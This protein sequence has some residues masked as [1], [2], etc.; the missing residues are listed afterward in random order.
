ML[1]MSNAAVFGLSL[2]AVTATVVTVAGINGAFDRWIEPSRVVSEKQAPVVQ[3]KEPAAKSTPAE[4]PAATDEASSVSSDDKVEEAEAIMPTKQPTV[5]IVRVEPSG[6]AV[7]AGQSDAGALVAVLSNGAM[8]GKGVAN[9]AGDWAIV[10]DNPL[11]PGPHDIVVEARRNESTEAVQAEIMISVN[12]PE[13][14]SQGVLV[15]TNQPGAPTEVLQVPNGPNTIVADLVENDADVP[16]TT[17]NVSSTDTD[18][19]APATPAPGVAEEKTEE[20]AA[21]V[22]ADAGT[23]TK[24]GA[25]AQQA[26]EAESESIVVAK[27]EP[28]QPADVG[29]SAEKTAVPAVEPQSETDKTVVTEPASVAA[30]EPEPQAAPSEQAEP[31][32]VAASEPEPQAAPSEQAEPASV[33]ASEPEPQAAP[34]E[35]VETVEAAKP[36]SEAPAPETEAQADQVANLETKPETVSP[37]PEAVKAEPEPEPEKEVEPSV[38][39]KAVEAD[40]GQVYIAGESSGKGPIRVYI[41][42]KLLGQTEPSAEGQWVIKAPK[43]MAPGQHNVRADKVK[44]EKGAVLARAEVVFEREADEVALTAIVAVGSGAS[45]VTAGAD[46]DAGRRQIPAMI[47]RKGDSLWRISRRHYGHGIRYTTIYEANQG[48]I[49]NPD[50]IFPGQVFLLPQ[51]DLNWAGN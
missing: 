13:D 41:G 9:D 39:V 23:E 31:A 6:D 26:A 45:G 22:V 44:D 4:S 34:V 29:Q 30:S 33:A 42:E 24:T 49:Q 50:L 18:S 51:R 15:A 5:D 46:V 47:I 8:V 37:K 3:S 40:D 11:A 21:M 48:Q 1:G 27:A 12:V 17:E 14:E 16:E 10:I 43:D 36:A 38:T 2:T 20:Q 32:G 35:T 28:E 19:S 7:I 25:E